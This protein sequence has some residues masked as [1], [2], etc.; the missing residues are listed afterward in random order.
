[1]EK[2]VS[3]LRCAR[4]DV[5]RLE[6]LMER[7]F[8][9]LGGVRQ[10]IKPGMRVLL[11]VNL[12]MARKPEEFTTTHP[13]FV[14][15]L[16]RV[17]RRAGGEIVIAD[18]P[19]GLYS[20]KILRNTY[21]VCGMEAV[22]ERLGAELNFDL[23]ARAATGEQNALCRTFNFIEPYHRCDLLISVCKMKTHAMAGFTGAAKNL[24][25]LIP[26][27][28]K[29]E[30][31]FRFPDKKRFC[32]M[33]VDLVQTAKPA[34]SF[35]D[36]ITAMQG[37]GPSSGT[38]YEAGLTFAS[39]NPY[40]LDLAASYLA[41]FSLS[42]TPLTESAVERGLCPSCAEELDVVGEELSEVVLSGY[43]KPKTASM[44]LLKML[45]K[46]MRERAEKH[47]APRPVVRKKRCVGC[48]LCAESCPVETIRIVEKKAVIDE[49]KCIRCFCCQEMCRIAA[50][51]IKKSR[52][53]R[54]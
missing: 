36:G 26:G 50:I 30:Y 47:F 20:E 13:A 18:S 24:F 39:A 44:S 16:G 34:L 17:I 40:A 43:Q 33:L 9:S 6:Q 11:K 1:M 29:G 3:I 46:G 2:T 8:E 32:E 48:G 28:E 52:I 5:D 49:R 7:H 4:Y 45:P 10:Y 15:A 42:E 54:I 41:G 31:H 38:A 19:G 23:G 14:E 35:M 25:G 12:L 53:F 22:A 37:D 51:E 27:L 21:R